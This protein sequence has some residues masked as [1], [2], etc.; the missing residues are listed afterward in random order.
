MSSALRFSA[1]FG[2]TF[3]VL[4]VV[5]MEMNIAAFT[6]HP[7]LMEFGLGTEP[8]RSGPAMYWFGWMTT[9]AIGGLVLGA[10]ASILPVRGAR[11]WYA[12]AWLLPLGAM[13]ASLYF[14]I[15]FF[16]KV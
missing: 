8:A 9:S 10:V 2:A 5:A 6:Y 3:A 4:Y 1:V 11:P 14:M 12:L 7:R 15:P 16:T 13:L